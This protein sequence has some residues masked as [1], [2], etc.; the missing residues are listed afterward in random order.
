MG[1]AGSK[2][3][4]MLN[5]LPDERRIVLPLFIILAI[6]TY[7]YSV[8]F[9][10]AT[11]RIVTNGPDQ[12]PAIWIVD[13]IFT[14]AASGL[15]A[16]IVDRT[17]RVRL[18]AGLLAI[19]AVIY[20]V[21]VG[22]LSANVSQ[23]AIY[24]VMYLLADQ[25]YLILPL[26]FWALASD[27]TTLA[28]SR[29]LFPIIAGGLAVGSLVGNGTVIAS[30]SLIASDASR[31]L[32][33]IGSAGVL[34]LIGAIVLLLA[35]RGRT[36]RARQTSGVVSPRETLQVGTDV[37]RHVPL[38]KFMAVAMFLGGFALMLI[39][40][41]FHFTVG[42][43][44]TNNPEGIR[45]FYALFS[46]SLFLTTWLVQWAFTG[47]VLHTTNLKNAFWIFPGV[48]LLAAL[49]VA[50]GGLL[51]IPAIFAAVPAR[52][53]ARM[54]QRAWDEPARKA[55][56][57]LIPDERRGRVSTVLDSYIYGLAW[58]AGSVL[59]L[60][61]F[62]IPAISSLTRDNVIVAYLAAAVIVGLGAVWGAMRLRHDYD[63]SLLNWR[64]AR[65]RRKSVLDGIDI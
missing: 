32:F 7:V 48:L 52:F 13:M 29:R 2:S 33:L 53:I 60:L 18:L 55:A 54:V 15:Y 14:I 17:P 49:L 21:V 4:Q 1:N 27:V 26:A 16:L 39:E 47:R 35:F 31:V 8:T 43:F 63:E 24:W 34:S 45:T 46:V 19:I 25:G 64:L 59:L 37:V 36:I 41:H 42:R 58:I 3:W 20:A 6:N 30:R 12:L 28:Q 23:I 65:S 56:Q 57:N 62:Q 61:L 51:A 5:L 22:I 50:G 44:F 11:A 9:V 10:V 38:F 40:Y